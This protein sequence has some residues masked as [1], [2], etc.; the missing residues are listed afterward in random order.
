MGRKEEQQ[1]HPHLIPTDIVRPKPSP[2]PHLSQGQLCRQTLASDRGSGG[3]VARSGAVDTG[4]MLP[5][6][7]SQ[8]HRERAV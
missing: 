7:Q 2:P 8:P 6:L 5:G 1:T 4:D 3:H